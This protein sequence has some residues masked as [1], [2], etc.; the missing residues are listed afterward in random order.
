MKKLCILL[1]VLISGCTTAPVVM[2][3][4]EKPQEV[5]ACPQLDTITEDLKISEVTKTVVKNYGSY[6]EC[7]VKVDTWNEWYETQKKIFES[8]SK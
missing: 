3:F 7:A 1:A 8:V 5:S 4:P 6:Y 2:K